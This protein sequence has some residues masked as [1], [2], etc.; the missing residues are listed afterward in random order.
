MNEKDF[1]SLFSHHYV[2]VNG[3]RLHYVIGGA[4]FQDAEHNRE[5]AETKL[6]MPVLTLVG[7]NS[8]NG[9]RLFRGAQSVFAEGQERNRAL[10]VWGAIAA[11][12]FAA[13]GWLRGI[14]TDTLSWRSVMFVN[15]P[16][17]LLTLVLTPLLLQESRALS[18]TQNV[19]LLG[20][21]TVTSG[22]VA[23]V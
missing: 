6:T 2:E 1:D 16:I 8:G 12:G 21:V 4:V 23:L 18:A 14:L 11:G 13:G 17:G 22:L 3:I 19:D 10:S 5:L 7:Q 15:V 9:D 20:A